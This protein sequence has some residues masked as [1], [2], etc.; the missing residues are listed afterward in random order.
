MSNDIE[1]QVPNLNGEGTGD[2][3]ADGVPDSSQENV[4]SLPNGTNGEYVTFAAASGQ[5]LSDVTAIETPADAP[6]EANFTQGVFDF[7]VVGLNPGE[8][9]SVQMIL[10]DNNGNNSNN[11]YW[12][13]GPTPDNPT[14]HWYNFDF[15]GTTGVQIEGN[16]IT[17]HFVDGARGDA[18][19][20]ANGQI[21]DPGAPA[22]YEE[23]PTAM[24]LT[25]IKAQ[26]TTD[27][28]LIVGGLMTLLLAGS[29]L[30]IRHRKED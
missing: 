17:L 28:S 22:I 18:D 5:L 24:T 16:I 13:Y 9:T 1:D 14:D 8:A 27:W 10:H 2:G 23:A 15:D 29:L 25:Q 20:T 19:L 4:T 30:L 7:A 6:Q 21:K 12:K 3:N 11:S 26:S